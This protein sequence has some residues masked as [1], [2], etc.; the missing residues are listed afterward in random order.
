MLRREPVV[1]A[2]VDISMP[3]GA[4]MRT[5]AIRA[6][7]ALNA[8]LESSVRNSCH[9]DKLCHATGHHAEVGEFGSLRNHKG[10]WTPASHS[11]R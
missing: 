9:C 5:V 2:E 3:D 1:D 4:L 10:S 6:W 8:Q 11:Q 7:C